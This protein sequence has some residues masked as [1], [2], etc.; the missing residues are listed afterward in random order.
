MCIC[1]KGQSI[2]K[3]SLC[4]VFLL[5]FLLLPATGISKSPPKGFIRSAL[6]MIE[7]KTGDSVLVGERRFLVTKAT[8]IVTVKGKKIQLSALPIPCKAEIEYLLRMDEDPLTLKIRI[9]RVL[10]GARK[11]WPPPGLEG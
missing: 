11:T 7:G 10:R 1:Y 9:K 8:T 3:I 5:I 2:Y 6:V 4:L